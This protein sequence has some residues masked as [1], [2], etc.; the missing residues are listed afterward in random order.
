MELPDNPLAGL[1]LDSETNLPEKPSYSQSFL[2]TRQG[3]R[4]LPFTDTYTGRDLSKYIPFTGEDINTLRDLDLEEMRAQGQGWELVPKAGAQALAEIVGGTIEGVGYIL[5]I[6]DVI[7]NLWHG[8]D[9]EW[10]NVISEFGRRAKEYVQNDLAPIYQ[11][12]EAQRGF[13]LLDPTWWASNAPSIASTLSLLIPVGLAARGVTRGA[14]ALAALGGR[15]L[16]RGAQKATE[17]IIGGLLSRHTE[18]MMEGAETF[19]R[20]VREGLSPEEAGEIALS[21]YRNGYWLLALDM[22]QYGALLKAGSIANRNAK[23]AFEVASGR[24]VLGEAITE[25]DLAE[26]GI[27]RLDW[28]KQMLSEGGEE[29]FQ[30]A[31]QRE[32][33][34]K[35]D[36]LTGKATEDRG[37]IARLG[38]MVL[39]RKAWDSFIFG[40]LGGGAF[41]AAGSIAQRRVEGPRQEREKRQLEDLTRRANVVRGLLETASGFQALGRTDLVEEVIDAGTMELGLR[42]AMKGNIGM[43]REMLRS[44]S[45]LSE[46]ELAERGFSPEAKE[47]AE[48]GLRVLSTIESA[49]NRYANLDYKLEENERDQLPSL[50][51]ELTRTEAGLHKLR[52]KRNQ[53][54]EELSRLE[55]ERETN[56]LA[57]EEIGKVEKELENVASAIASE[58]KRL[59]G[60]VKSKEK[61]TAFFKARVRE[62]EARE[63]ARTQQ[64]EARAAEEREASAKSP[65]TSR[66]EDEVRSVEEEVNIEDIFRP[67]N[68]PPL[69]VPPDSEMEADLLVE[70]AAPQEGPLR[71]E[72]LE[73]DTPIVLSP[74]P[75]ATEAPLTEAVP[76]EEAPV[77]EAPVAE[78]PTTSAETPRN[79]FAS[80]F[81]ASPEDQDAL[82]EESASEVIE[83]APAAAETPTNPFAS[84]FAD[85]SEDVVGE[86]DS[87]EPTPREKEPRSQTQVVY[88]AMGEPDTT[89]EGAEESAPSIPAERGAGYTLQKLPVHRKD[90][91]WQRLIA[92]FEKQTDLSGHEI[93]FDFDPNDA[94]K[95]DNLTTDQYNALVRG[96][97]IVRDGDR[98]VFEGT[99]LEIDPGSLSIRAWFSKNGREIKGLRSWMHKI[100]KWAEKGHTKTEVQDYRDLRVQ[101]YNA[102][103][104][105]RAVSAPVS[106]PSGHQDEGKRRSTAGRTRVA[107]NDMKTPFR[108]AIVRNG[109]QG[110][111]YY[112]SSDEVW[113]GAVP[114][115]DHRG[116][117]HAILPMPGGRET[118]WKL[119]T[120]PVSAEEAALVWY[121]YRE[122]MDKRSDDIRLGDMA[123]ETRERIEAKLGRFSNVRVR[124]LAN[125]IVNE[126]EST[127]SEKEYKKGRTLHLRA[128][129]RTVFVGPYEMKVKG[130]GSVLV[131]EGKNQRTIT[132]VE[133]AK[134][135]IRTLRKHKR[136]QVHL[137]GIAQNSILDLF[138]GETKVTLFGKNYTSYQDYLSDRDVVAFDA[139]P[140]Y[141]KEGRL[142]ENPTIIYD[143]PSFE[144][145]IESTVEEP[146]VPQTPE[147]SEERVEQEG[148]TPEEIDKYF[149]LV[150]ETSKPQKER[151]FEE[152][153][154]W[155]QEK[156][157]NVPLNI[158]E[159]LVRVKE[160]T[161]SA[162]GMFSRGMITLSELAA[163]GTAY[164]EAFHAVFHLYLSPEEREQIL[165]EAA[166]RYNVSRKPLSEEG[167]NRLKDALTRLG[168]SQEE[169][170]ELEAEGIAAGATVDLITKTLRYQQGQEDTLPREAAYVMW[171]LVSKDSQL[172][173]M[174]HTYLPL[175]SGYKASLSRHQKEGAD[176]ALVRHNVALDL[177]ESVLREELSEK[178]SQESTIKRLLT[179]VKEI[180]DRWLKVSE[181][182][183]RDLAKDF[184]GA[185]EKYFNKTRRADMLATSME[186]ALSA[187]PRASEI[188]SGL[189]DIG[190]L[191]TGSLALREQ[192][193]VYRSGEESLHDLDFTV[194]RDA[195]SEDADF[196]AFMEK[197]EEIFDSRNKNR[198]K[199][200]LDELSKRVEDSSFVKK[201][202]EA[203]PTYRILKQFHGYK[204]EATVVLGVID[205]EFDAKGNYIEDTGYKIDFFISPTLTQKEI[206]RDG[207]QKWE[208][209]FRAKLQM[210]RQK[211]LQ[212]F[213]NFEP[214]TKGEPSKEGLRHISLQK[215]KE[216]DLQ[217]EERL[218]EDFR[219]YVQARRESRT[220][221]FAD[222][223][224]DLFQ[225]LWNLIQNVFGRPMTRERLFRNIE[226]GVYRKAPKKGYDGVRYKLADL[227]W[228]ARQ[229][230]TGF[231]VYMMM[232]KSG[233][234][235]VEDVT[236][237]SFLDPVFNGKN[238]REKHWA[239]EGVL[240]G[241]ETK[242]GAEA[243][244][245][246]LIRE[247]AGTPDNPGELIREVRIFLRGLGIQQKGDS[248]E[249]EDRGEYGEEV[250]PEFETENDDEGTLARQISNPFEFSNKATAAQNIL[251]LIATIPEVRY[252]EDGSYEIVKSE[253][254]P[255][256]PVLADYAKLWKKLEESLSDLVDGYE[257]GVRKTAYEKMMERLKVMR[258]TDARIGKL[259]DALFDKNYPE[260]KRTQFFVAFNKVNQ[261]F[262]DFLWARQEGQ[263]LFTISGADTQ[264]TQRRLIDEWATAFHTPKEGIH[265][266]MWVDE[267]EIP[268]INTATV[269]KAVEWWE[270]FR[271]R[272][273]NPTERDVKNL[274]A[275]LDRLGV[276]VSPGGWNAYMELLGDSPERQLIKLRSFLNDIVLGG[277]NSQKQS[278]MS[279]YRMSSRAKNPLKA[280]E[281]L[282]KPIVSDWSIFEELA[283]AEALSR[284]E[285]SENTVFGPGAKP[286]YNYSLP[287]GLQE[288]ILRLS[289]PNDSIVED[290]LGM[291]FY[292]RSRLLQHLRNPANR[293]RLKVGTYLNF[294]ELYGGDQ[295]NKFPDLKLGD[296]TVMR[297]VMAMMGQY[298]TLN[299]ADKSN[300]YPIEGL[301]TLE[302]AYEVHQSHTPGVGDLSGF[303][304]HSGGAVGSDTAW[305]EIGREY[306]MVQNKHYY[307]GK[308]TPN[309][310]T[311]ITDAEYREGVEKVRLANRALR[312]QPDKYMSLLA[313]NWQ[314]VK[315]ADAVFA[316]GR[317]ASQT[318]VDGGT[319]WAVQMAID[320]GKPVYVFDQ[321]RGRWYAYRQQTDLL[322]N[323][324]G[325]V[326][327]ETETPILTKNFAGIGTRDLNDAGREAIRQVYE[328]TKNG[329]TIRDVRIGATTIKTFSDYFLSEYVRM[330]QAHQQ[331]KTLPKEK[332]VQYY[333]SGNAFK[334]TVFPELSPENLR[335]SDP[336][337]YAL[338]YDSEG[339]PLLWNDVT[340]EQ[341]DA[342]YAAIEPVIRQA[343][344]D[345]VQEQLDDLVEKALLKKTESGYETTD[346]TWIPNEVLGTKLPEAVIGSAVINQT[347]A[348]FELMSILH[349]DYAAYESV[350][351]LDK[352][353][354]EIGGFGL[355]LRTDPGS[356]VSPTFRVAVM[357]DVVR[358][359]EYNGFEEI[360]ETSG[361]K[362]SKIV[363]YK[364]G[365]GFDAF[366]HILHKRDGGTLFDAKKK[367]ARLLKSYNKV[368]VVDGQGYMTLARFREVMIGFGRWTPRHEELYPHVQR[369]EWPREIQELYDEYLAIQ[370]YKK[371]PL[372]PVH[373]EVTN[374]ENAP[375]PVFL[376]YST[377]VLFPALTKNTPLDKLRV[378]LEAQNIQEAVFES[379]VK[380]G[381]R[382]ITEVFDENGLVKDNIQ[383]TP[384]TLSNSKWRLQVDL[385]SK[386]AHDTLE[387][388]QAR[389]LIYVNMLMDGDYKLD[390]KLVKGRD[391]LKMIHDVH[392]AISDLGWESLKEEWGI[393][394]EGRITNIEGLAKTL[395]EEFEGKEATDNLLDSLKVEGGA[396][397]TPLDASTA[398]SQIQNMMFSIL[399]K[400][401]V[402]TKTFGGSFIQLSAN[403]LTRPRGTKSFSEEEK[404]QY[405]FDRL[406]PPQYDP[407]T[408]TWKPGGVLLPAY[409]G[410]EV[411]KA[412]GKR[413]HE[414]TKEEIMK[415]IDPEVLRIV[416]YRIP[417]QGRGSIDVAQVEGFLPPEA[418]DTIVM[419]D[420]VTAKT[421]SDFDIDKMYVMLPNTKFDG[422]KVRKIKYEEGT[423]DRRALENRILELYEAVLSHPEGY[424]ESNTPLGVVTGKLKKLSEDIE[425]WIQ[426][427]EKD[428]KPKRLESLRWLT[429]LHQMHNKQKFSVGKQL[430]GSVALHLSHIPV[431]QGAGLYYNGK[432]LDSW[433]INLGR[434]WEDLK[435]SFQVEEDDDGWVTT[436][437]ESHNTEGDLIS[438]VLSAK[439]DG[440]V[441]VAKGAW[442]YGLGFNSI[443]AN[444]DLLL[445]RA[446][447]RP[448][449]IALFLQQPII[450]DYVR[451]TQ[452]FESDLIEARDEKGKLLS[453]KEL[454]VREWRKNL[455]SAVK[456]KESRNPLDL[457]VM[458]N[459]IRGQ[460]KDEQFYRD[461]LAIL[462]L[463]TGPLMD[464]G[465]ALFDAVLASKVDT[466]GAGKN[467]AEWMVILERFNSVLNDERLGNF[468]AIFKRGG[469][470]T[471]H[472][473][474]MKNGVF[475]VEA[476]LSGIFL[477]ISPEFRGV[478][479]RVFE[480]M[481][482]SKAQDVE[483]V[484]KVLR[485]TF[486]AALS[487]TQIAPTKDEMQL[488]FFG[489]NTLAHRLKAL[490]DTEKH[491]P[492]VT[493]NELIRYLTANFGRGK[494]SPSFVQG[495]GKVKGR[496][497]ANALKEAWQQL[498]ESEDAEVRS[499]AE[500]LVRYAY[501]TSG[502]MKTIYGFYDLIPQAY[503]QKIGLGE[504][505]RRMPMLVEENAEEIASQFF[506]HNWQD[507][508]LVPKVRS[509]GILASLNDKGVKFVG[510][511]QRLV[512]QLDREKAEN[513]KI[514][515]ERRT[516]IEGEEVTVDIFP[517]YVSYLHTPS[518]EELEVNPNAKPTENLYELVGYA[519]NWNPVYNKVAPLGTVRAG[520]KVYEYDI[521]AASRGE[522]AS[523]VFN[524]NVEYRQQVT[525][526]V[527]AAESPEFFNLD[528]NDLP[529][530]SEGNDNTNCE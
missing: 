164:H 237:L 9:A 222:K 112:F 376:K 269:D 28:A 481:G 238:G 360:R 413:L 398:R 22:L 361:D 7:N 317:L 478:V 18:G 35:I 44:I 331:A 506:R 507:T 125:L 468:S 320:A 6:P 417:T 53:L 142:F 294:K 177:L 292:E 105:G 104:E 124:D 234:R 29:L 386:G 172:R 16:G 199:L 368:N 490:Q 1:P 314:Q 11:T 185:Q 508:K 446:G 57:E 366:V 168:F 420:E 457:K 305:D 219:E 353:T 344:I 517:R 227:S 201:V 52:E 231:M 80:R 311:P 99:T 272:L 387:G 47:R 370:H 102:L 473:T 529:D 13:A 448:E 515:S 470:L 465:K 419:F 191:L 87:A 284:G 12:R 115:E 120:R 150:P 525:Y 30:E 301:P 256:L 268:H 253:V 25:A 354:P 242:G 530:S 86:T 339:V 492:E 5:D 119:N 522:R 59:D 285:G 92:Y 322:G 175:W 122:M 154:A 332:Q 174:I 432:L 43:E 516:T 73:E 351:D 286:Y 321:S 352:R 158:I 118:T 81:E 383:F 401:T 205:G 348:H 93:H 288:Q 75:E 402:R 431:A 471:M 411:E 82:E 455:E 251:L 239:W 173:R 134:L 329:E 523:S 428:T 450:R 395:R 159:D 224:A 510:G 139:D 309:G 265:R 21:T 433:V 246:A 513:Y 335:T 416:T 76:A 369:G 385:P 182:V 249:N 68:E 247:H 252:K 244:T 189:R 2:K 355:K 502:W 241:L 362:K 121:L 91:E 72:P 229:H 135:F 280:E 85:S 496:H 106:I 46:E 207:L 438:D 209:I 410:R 325:G 318:Q 197:G 263:F 315:N 289:D 42:A 100:G 439:L 393:D 342:L 480:M 484:E 460:Y 277:S 328:K 192:G 96:Q 74:E 27:K 463:F 326:F 479:T 391:L 293:R 187:D 116:Q 257:N 145:A 310:N 424:V 186:E 442:L 17:V 223:V 232:T 485:H 437:A 89:D 434:P 279:L 483:I 512:F 248:F 403:G 415:W 58:K 493:E 233:V 213:F 163:E 48:R 138:P 245:A 436:L 178:E 143:T 298:S 218:A 204:Q 519:K 194:A 235:G 379:G 425:G 497:H 440:T 346:N 464:A 38:E 225:R 283:Y 474:Y 304:N 495:S 255:G 97:R 266:F 444:V 441:D 486:T 503:L 140:E 264:S 323:S 333:H 319:G 240:R 390:G 404:K 451:K 456:T 31:I 300:F 364:G 388:S 127:R 306:G 423:T 67:D 371:Q 206:E 270:E 4:M 94:A 113:Q 133:A 290:L 211:D 524:K 50:L 399:R 214:R 184:L 494:K 34:F 514:G 161:G 84:K 215:T 79:P 491:G 303:V 381:A 183:A 136:P 153:V 443:T 408:D 327:V 83:A 243:A 527:I 281:V 196:L 350:A 23:K 341:E 144:E 63:Q 262:R 181:S 71:E 88:E 297:L 347:M 521:T 217:I 392:S 330:G 489:D 200:Y 49:Y 41:H 56:P 282:N 151:T 149:R 250:D 60:L 476:L 69:A 188:V 426:E 275:F 367:A 15:P 313:R 452:I 459:S 358:K 488:F 8:A 261:R 499:F 64:A 169:L 132:E 220:L 162:Y 307:Y 109:E 299:L 39:D 117:V 475:P 70:D 203:F 130:D 254:L 103:Q 418:G 509:R 78:T 382:G 221:S 171:K 308:K 62:E 374:Y 461:Q 526:P 505:V 129:S 167:L 61:R 469:S 394:S 363:D 216:T 152:E 148:P 380:V 32:A 500:A 421:G 26:A 349:G 166:R 422:E 176:E 258:R 405:K 126:G 54:G 123:P 378:Q 384:I 108:L 373:F 51:Y 14:A 520:N 414:M 260:Y 24:A 179:K 141:A 472:G 155:L 337:T 273:D 228:E 146:T 55:S 195:F 98:Y 180:L 302:N 357:K 295:G 20:A 466:Q 128:K 365:P 276:E 212:D 467:V 504:D 198:I 343:L 449:F 400:R 291:P 454:V 137:K 372:K 397:V 110:L 316:V 430:T 210:G 458:E 528:P 65:A 477:D 324:T 498:L 10:G 267:N 336:A 447:A 340:S 3:A 77:A 107:L 445:S 40:A 36:L 101:I 501:A 193:T 170:A 312:R 114:S 226:A 356:G 407:E 359:S 66:L 95:Y 429:P 230:A 453:A 19:E 190:A 511:G 487:G 111:G 409:M 375:I 259:L 236:K 131:K 334:S 406:T 435:K 156:L 462:E 377:A 518:N 345:R 160:N 165:Q 338:L 274:L 427:A 287:N 157:P 33:D 208:Y 37:L 271:D 396:F 202:Q 389:K 482:R 278:A 90:P 296:E 147:K 412:A 45:Q